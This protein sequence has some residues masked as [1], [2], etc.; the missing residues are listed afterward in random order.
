MTYYKVFGLKFSLYLEGSRKRE[1]FC[2]KTSKHCEPKQQCY[3]YSQLN[4]KPLY[5]EGKLG[6][7]LQSSASIE[8]QIEILVASVCP[9]STD[10]AGCEEAVRMYWSEIGKSK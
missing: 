6:D 9:E 3:K 1:N 5:C 4:A 7:Y 8:E 2:P 10:P